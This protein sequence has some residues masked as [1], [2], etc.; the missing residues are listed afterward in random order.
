MTAGLAP[1]ADGAH[2]DYSI[3]YKRTPEARQRS[4]GPGLNH[5]NER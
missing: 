3:T 2:P 5:L 4:E 1:T